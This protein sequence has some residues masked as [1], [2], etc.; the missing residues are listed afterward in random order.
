MDT[1]CFS[2]S[3]N[4]LGRG[5]TRHFELCGGWS[6]RCRARVVWS[7]GHSWCRQV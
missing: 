3:D 1:S 4:F 5:Y 2:W 6:S 7:S